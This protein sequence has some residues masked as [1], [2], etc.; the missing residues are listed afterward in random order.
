MHTEDLR[1]VHDV[2]DHIY[3]SPHLDDAV[4]SCGGAIARHS[5]AGARVLI[6]TIC[7][8]SPP[9]EGPF[10]SFA[11]E[12]HRQWGLSAGQVVRARLHEDSL[13][14]EHL[15]VDSLWVGMLDAI[16]RRPADYM[17]DATL[18]GA[19]A[20]DDPLLPS[21]KAFTRALRDR[22]PRATLY[23]P[24]GV[25]NHVDHQITYAAAR[26]A[27]GTAIAFYEDFPYVTKPNALDQRLRALDESFVTSTLDIDATLS[28]K[29]GAIAAYT[30]QIGMLFGDVDAMRQQVRAYAEELRPDVGTYGERLWLLNA[31]S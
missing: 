27:A 19:L 13:A 16:Y 7:T 23:A 28:R 14:M 29:I 15:G 9:P 20:P 17:S 5:A 22:V 25:G 30:S 26:A 1:Q 21:L 2:Y 10:S 8:A 12:I 3:L 11:E 31:Q 4:L 6:V 18:F 24:L